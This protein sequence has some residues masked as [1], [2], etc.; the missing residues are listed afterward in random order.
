MSETFLLT[1]VPLMAELELPMK[2]FTEIPIT[3]VFHAYEL[4][5]VVLQITYEIVMILQRSLLK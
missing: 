4:K 5:F 3:W 2:L 1:S